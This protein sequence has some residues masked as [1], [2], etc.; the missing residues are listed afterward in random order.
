MLDP[1]FPGE[2]FAMN[3]TDSKW[4]DGAEPLWHAVERQVIDSCAH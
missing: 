1:A 3:T 4:W 2:R